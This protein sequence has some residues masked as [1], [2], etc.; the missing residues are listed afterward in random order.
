MYRKYTNNTKSLILEKTLFMKKVLQKTKQK[1]NI[2]AE[3]EK[4]N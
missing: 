2:K 4:N 3:I 1:K